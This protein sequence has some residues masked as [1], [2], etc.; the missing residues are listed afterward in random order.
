LKLSVTRL[1]RDVVKRKLFRRS[2]GSRLRRRRR[3]SASVTSRREQLTDSLR[4][5][6]SA[7]S[8]PLKKV[9]ELPVLRN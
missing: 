4:L 1:T 7:R 3:S 5:T 2:L 9:R 6:L 8:V